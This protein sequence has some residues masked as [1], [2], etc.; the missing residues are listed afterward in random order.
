MS[1]EADAS[2]AWE[3]EEDSRALQELLGQLPEHWH[4]CSDG[5]ERI[6]RI[7]PDGEMSKC[8]TIG[9]AFRIERVALLRELAEMLNA[10]AYKPEPECVDPQMQ[11]AREGY[12]EG[13]KWAGKKLGWRADALEKGTP[14]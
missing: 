5:H 9:D 3:M 13:L 12:R 14:P 10:E 1:D 6:Y 2:G 11:A 8:V 7:M 4:R